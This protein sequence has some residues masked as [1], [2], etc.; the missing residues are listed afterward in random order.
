MKNPLRRA[1][2]F[3]GKTCAALSAAAAL[4]FAAAWVLGNWHTRPPRP[5]EPRPVAVYLVSNGVHSDIVMPVSTPQWNWRKWAT[6]SHTRTA[7]QAAYI[8][9]GW[10]EKGFYLNTPRWRDLT[11]QTAL[12]AL[13]GFN[14]TAMHIT[15]YPAEPQ[16]GEYVARIMLSEAEYRRLA[17]QI[18][19]SFALADGRP[20]Q[21]AGAAYHNTDA[22]YEANGRYSLFNTCNTW[23]NNQ[24]KQT[25]LPAVVW[26]PFA[27][28]VLDRY[29][30]EYSRLK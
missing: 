10:G 13:S 25:A 26:T 1:A 24:F 23:T 11:A 17:G 20:Q 15:F 21:I 29:R 5:A 3:I 12:K 2:A 4:Y 22:F 18:A 16:T 8:G 30:E 6:E 7:F 19:K 14:E 28:A 9:I 27:G